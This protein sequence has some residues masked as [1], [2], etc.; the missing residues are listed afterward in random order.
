[1]PFGTHERSGPSQCLLPQVDQDE[2]FERTKQ[3]GLASRTELDGRD[4]RIGPLEGQ[5]LAVDHTAALIGDEDHAVP[6][7]LVLCPDQLQAG[8]RHR[9]R[10][11]GVAR[12]GQRDLPERLVAWR[13]Q[14]VRR[15]PVR[16]KHEPAVG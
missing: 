5:V 11:D 2:F 4:L 6:A 12:V 1:M 14:Q 9:D 10:T 13:Y 7:A 3:R 15:G 16:R 8:V